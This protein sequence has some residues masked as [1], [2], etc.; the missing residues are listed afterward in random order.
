MSG[1]SRS[2]ETAAGSCRPP[3]Q[4]RF[5]TKLLVRISETLAIR[6]SMPQLHTDSSIGAS[7]NLSNPKNSSLK[8]RFIVDPEGPLLKTSFRLV[9]GAARSWRREGLPPT[10]ALP[11]VET[12]KGAKPLIILPTERKKV[13]GMGVSPFLGKRRPWILL[14]LPDWEESS[15]SPIIKMESLGACTC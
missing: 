5:S 12:G 6:M 9:V 11:P 13:Q 8:T 15:C 3:P 7:A 10:P 2:G 14:E 4:S 1:A